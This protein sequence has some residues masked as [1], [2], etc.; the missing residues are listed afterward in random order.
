VEVVL[1][2]EVEEA[3]VQLEVQLVEPQCLMDCECSVMVVL[4]LMFRG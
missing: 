4:T 2:V 3:V 1:L